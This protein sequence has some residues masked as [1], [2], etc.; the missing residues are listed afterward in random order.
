VP[1][2]LRARDERQLAARAPD[3]HVRARIPG[4]WI[5]DFGKAEAVFEHSRPAVE[6]LRRKLVT[7]GLARS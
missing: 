1:S 6:E 3:I 5:L 2:L 7:M 4:V